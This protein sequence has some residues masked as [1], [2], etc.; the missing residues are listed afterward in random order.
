MRVETRAEVVATLERAKGE[1]QAMARTVE[2]KIGMVARAFEGLAGHTDTLLNLAAAIVGCVEN[3]RVSSILPKVQTLGAAARVFIGERLEATTG[4]LETVTAEVK[5]LRQLSRVAGDQ[6]AIALEIKALSVLTNI[7]VARLG[8]VG[9]GFQYLASE[10]SNFSK[11][12]TED[13]KELASHT[14]GR[15]VVIEEIRRVLSAELPR[16]R[17]ELARIE[18]D[19]G[20]ALAVVDSSLTQLSSTPAQF[21][22]CVEDIAQQI[23][24]VV[25]AIQAHDITR[26][27]I[28]HVQEAFALIAASMRNPENPENGA[29]PELPRAYAGLTI[30]IYQLRTIKETVA[31]WASQIGTCMSGILRVSAS[32]VVGIGPVVLEQER[33]VSSQLVQIEMLER[34]SQAYSVRIQRTLGGLSNLMQLVSEHLQRSKSVRDRLRL[35]A[36]NSII[37]AS[38]LGTQADAILAISKSIKGISAAWGQITEQSGHAMQEILNLVKQTNQ[39]MEAFSD[40][41]NERLRDAQVETRGALDN[42]RTAAEFA[43]GQARQMKAATE[44]MQAQIAGVGKTGDLLDACFGCGDAVLVEVEGLR[45]QLETDYPDVKERYDPDEVE[46]LFSASYTT[47]MERDV[48]RLALR[49][50]P[51]PVGQPTFAGNSVELF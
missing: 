29:V 19:L 28:E 10:L 3:E 50:T 45:R 6:E 7:E 40:A 47:E 36:F 21:R 34:E 8:A 31:N 2:S 22:T 37:E 24:G 20:N 17:E 32:D 14:D 48:L 9:A 25:A 26:Q 38:H 5:L 23:A 35:L 27:Q 11:S 13:T 44:K 39:V 15:R 43:A 4:I 42:L 30:Q 49:G 51:L 16:L 33:N 18:V 41:S 12:V 46:R 1:L